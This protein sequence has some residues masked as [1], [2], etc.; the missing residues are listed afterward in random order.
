MVE[1]IKKAQTINWPGFNPMI[2]FA[3]ALSNGEFFSAANIMK[4]IKQGHDTPIGWVS[5]RVN[6]QDGKR[7][8]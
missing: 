1:D 5:C 6:R 7:T 8:I 2:L 4:G 3:H